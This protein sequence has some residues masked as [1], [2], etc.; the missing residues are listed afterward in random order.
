MGGVCEVDLE[1]SKY[2]NILVR[3]KLI[4]LVTALGSIA[5]AA[6]G[7]HYM[8]PVYQTSTILRVALSIGGTLSSAD[9]MY[10]DRLM[11]TY[12]EIATSQPVTEELVT[13]LHLTKLPDLHVEIIPNT[14]L[15]QIMVEDGDPDRAA[16]IAN[17]L[18]DILIT[19]EYQLYTGI[20]KTSSQVLS[21]QLTESKADFDQSLQE[22]QRLL[23]QTPAPENIEVAS[24]SVQINQSRY[25]AL[26]TQYEQARI[27]EETRANMV[28]VLQTA[29]VPDR[30]IKPSLVLNIA[31][32]VFAGLVAGFGIALLFENLDPTLY[33]IE[34]IEAVTKLS[35]L[36]KIPKAK[37]RERTT[38]QGNFSPFSEAFRN[39]A[40]HLEV[41]IRQQSK[42]VLLLVS[43]QPQQGKSMIT[44]HLACA[45]AELGKNVIAV[46]CDTRRPSLHS[47][48]QL[49]NEVGLK[50]VLEQSLS[51]EGALQKS[52]FE[53]VQVL[54]SG[55]QLAHPS[56]M[57]SSV[58]MTK[59]IRNLS[60]Q[61]DYVLLDS[62]AML[63]VAD[64]TALVPNA[65]SLILV[66]R[67]A[68]AERDS[69]EAA[70]RFLAAQDSKFT[71]L[72]LNQVENGDHY[73]Y[74]EDKKG[75]G[76]LLAF[77]KRMSRKGN[78]SS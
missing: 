22:Y 10:T 28:T 40:T 64:V 73:Y 69:V 58:Q 30:P 68:Y 70:G 44:F 51:L 34:E 50:D 52:P 31:L 25:A 74:Y 55:S 5:S 4:I 41:T 38:F 3:R 9:Y 65:G 27:R 46:D 16:L 71:G 78:R 57:L 21:E 23:I 72:I 66:V 43:A 61:F 26:L 54:T 42:K 14:E 18:A 12:V 15:I 59:L 39:L 13:R 47:Y 2:I 37:G 53:A 49:P 1:L 32:A 6:V 24:Y 20:G 17:T 45:L 36:V 75:L 63:S 77:V 11:N 48:F 76:P 33:E 60:Q 7:T 8:T 35:A 56:Q 29:T 19:Q 62:P 67:R